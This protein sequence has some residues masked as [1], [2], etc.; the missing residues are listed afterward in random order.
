[1]LSRNVAQNDTPSLPLSL[2]TA[3]RF[4]CISRS[5]WFD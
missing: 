3:E 4:G 2:K 5:L 1:L